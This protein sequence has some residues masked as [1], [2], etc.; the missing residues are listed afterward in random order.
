L[1]PTAHLVLFEDQTFLIQCTNRTLPFAWGPADAR[2]NAAQ[3]ITATQWA[4][5]HAA[6]WNA[7]TNA[8]WVIAPRGPQAMPTSFACPLWLDVDGWSA[9]AHQLLP[10]ITALV[11]SVALATAQ[12]S[13]GWT[14]DVHNGVLKPSGFEPGFL[15]YDTHGTVHAQGLFLGLTARVQNALAKD[16]RLQRLLASHHLLVHR[17]VRG[18]DQRPTCGKHAVVASFQVGASSAHQRLAGLATLESLLKALP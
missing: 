8:D 2:T 1:D 10:A 15:I 11:D 14:M 7:L 5:A 3:A 9:N 12:E 13:H 4:R 16:G 18:P 6:T 17:H